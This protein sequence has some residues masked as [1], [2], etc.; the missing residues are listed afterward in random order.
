MESYV[1][2]LLREHSID[3]T[4]PSPATSAILKAS[5]ESNPISV[6]EAEKLH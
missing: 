3:S 6:E 5:D 1:Q 2:M 4:A